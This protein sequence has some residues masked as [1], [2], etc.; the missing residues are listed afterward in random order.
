M[1]WQS[2]A[3]NSSWNFILNQMISPES[4]EIT[5][6]I[7]RTAL[8]QVRKFFQIIQSKLVF[9]QGYNLSMCSVVLIKLLACALKVT[10]LKEAKFIL[11]VLNFWLRNFCKCLER[12]SIKWLFGLYLNPPVERMSASIQS[13][14]CNPSLLRK[15][16]CK[17]ANVRV[18][19]PVPADA[20]PGSYSIILI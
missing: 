19:A 7:I 12:H 15:Y 18:P 9:S 3:A 16:S 13:V 8:K 17:A 1:N 14:H 2:N 6:K 4:A 10:Y 11:V 20:I 5:S